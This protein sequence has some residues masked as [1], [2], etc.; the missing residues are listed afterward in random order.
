MFNQ[1]QFAAAAA[2]WCMRN[3]VSTERLGLTLAFNGRYALTPLFN[4]F[5]VSLEEDLP[6]QFFNTLPEAVSYKYE[7][8]DH[9]LLANVLVYVDGNIESL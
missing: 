1:M 8:I 9:G 3:G 5:A 6:Q 4:L 2:Q 7:A